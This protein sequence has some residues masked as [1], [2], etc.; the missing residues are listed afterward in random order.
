[1]REDRHPGNRGQCPFYVDPDDLLTAEASI[2]KCVTCATR[3]DAGLQ[4]C[5]DD[6]RQLAYLTILEET[7]KY[8]PTHPSQAS[9]IT[10][11]KSRV[12]HRL[13]SQ[14]RQELRYLPCSLVES[15]TSEFSDDV[16]TAL[17]PL[18]AEL[19][20]T[21]VAAESLEDEVIEEVHLERFR[22][23]LPVMLKRLTEQEQEIVRLKYFQDYTGTQ[24]AEALGI[25]KGRVS[26]LMKSLLGKLKSVYLRLK[27]G[28]P[29]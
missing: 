8:D 25:S 4:A 15:V 5:R 20:N 27:D 9:F 14:R 17:N 24:I 28:C 29:V 10:F 26:Q 18:A 13:W 11:I 3:G 2:C 21:A 23:Q 12:C 19:Y 7:P 22:E 16:P 1:M 6:F